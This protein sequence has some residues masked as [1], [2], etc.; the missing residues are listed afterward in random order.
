MKG[1]G[2]STGLPARTRK[3]RRHPVTSP[4][5]GTGKSRPAGA[6][7]HALL[8][9]GALKPCLTEGTIELD[10][11]APERAAAIHSPIGTEKLNDL[12][13]EA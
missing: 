10:N 1:K 7:R 6:I 5:R 3:F 4:R 9:W 12:A 11:H 8:R 2:H 13:P